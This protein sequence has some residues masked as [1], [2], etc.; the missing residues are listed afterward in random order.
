MI[1][2]AISGGIRP[3]APLSETLHLHWRSMTVGELLQVLELAE[4]QVGA[5]LVN[6]HPR[7]M[8]FK[9]KEGDVI[10]L[11]PVLGGG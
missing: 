3:Q 4:T 5:V 6:G 9:L 8:N 11:L 10:Q 1:Q 7:K 2:V